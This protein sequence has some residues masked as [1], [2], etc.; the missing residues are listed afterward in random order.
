MKS[1]FALMA[2]AT[3]LAA[4][5]A[6][7]ASG[8]STP[9]NAIGRILLQVEE[10]GEAWYVDPVTENRYYL[11]DGPLAYQALREFG[12]GITTNDLRGIPIG[13]QEY[14]GYDSDGDG[15]ED[16]F[17]EAI[18]TDGA[19]MDTDGDGFH[20]GL[21]ISN[22]YNP[23][24][25]GKQVINTALV[26]RVKGR[27]LLQVEDAGQAWYVSPVDGKRYYMRN[28]DAAY[29]IMRYMGLGATNETLGII[30]I[31][32]ADTSVISCDDDI[33]CVQ[34][35]GTAMNYLTFYTTDFKKSFSERT[36]GPRDAEVFGSIESTI[37]LMGDAP[38][39][40]DLNVLRNPSRT[41]VYPFLYTTRT[42]AEGNSESSLVCEVSR[43][44]LAEWQNTGDNNWFAEGAA[45][46]L[47]FSLGTD[48]DLTIENAAIEILET[49]ARGDFDLV[50]NQYTSAEFKTI[51]TANDLRE[52]TRATPALDTLKKATVF[53]QSELMDGQTEFQ[54]VKGIMQGDQAAEPYEIQF[55]FEDGNYVM[56]YLSLGYYEAEE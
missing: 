19:K 33:D 35:H 50:Y 44:T 9:R 23:F 32:E 42:F 37:D 18:G 25:K 24:G 3:L 5:T 26:D 34:G 15:L 54:V 49:L 45:C 8:P 46:N 38:V 28:G 52:M 43:E 30:P 55:V 48:E 51:A 20:D 22:G 56:S 27:I 13:G 41:P 29:F 6:T 31:H 21:E 12:L 4:P 47:H 1:L 11:K 16:K 7:F 14:G 39:R 10:R 17:E 40:M 36:I 53:D 2:V